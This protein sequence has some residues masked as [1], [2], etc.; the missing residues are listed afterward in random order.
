MILVYRHVFS[1][2]SPQSAKTLCTTDDECACLPLLSTSKCGGN[3]KLLPDQFMS[4][5]ST[6]SNICIK[7]IQ[8]KGLMRLFLCLYQSLKSKT[9]QGS[10][11]SAFS[12]LS[13]TPCTI[14]SWVCLPAS[15]PATINHK[16]STQPQCFSGFSVLL[17]KRSV[18][19][20]TWVCFSSS[21]ATPNQKHRL[22]TRC[23][24]WALSQIYQKKYPAYKW[25]RVSAS[26]LD[27]KF[28][29][30]LPMSVLFS[31]CS[32]LLKQWVWSLMNQPRNL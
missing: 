19:L 20:D 13:K 16:Y 7:I 24:L 17:F 18:P 26:G 29:F 31:V 14:S 32:A 10:T 5:A 1:R 6:L 12:A 11:M 28:S 8:L 4:A 3:Q 2:A 23:L 22:T 9:C 25:V 15:F 27:Q 21:I 30:E